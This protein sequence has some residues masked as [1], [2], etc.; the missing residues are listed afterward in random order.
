MKPGAAKTAGTGGKT[1]ARAKTR[2]KQE[3]T[4]AG[5]PGKLHVRGLGRRLNRTQL[6]ERLRLD[7]KTVSKYLAMQ[8]APRPDKRQRYDVA[9]AKT[10][11]E[12]NAPKIGGSE[13]LKKIRESM[14]RMEAEDMALDLE[15]RKG[16]LVKKSDIEPAIIAFTSALT[17]NLRTKFEFELPPKY[18]GL[19]AAARTKLN[20]DGIDW[21]IRQLKAGTAP[22]TQ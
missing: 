16:R 2:R 15:E 20:A 14:L 19:D 3:G 18:E 22:L 7:R 8:G 21:V 9:A 13:E 11:I 12:A 10:F 17:E 4:G 6:A 5:R 1:R